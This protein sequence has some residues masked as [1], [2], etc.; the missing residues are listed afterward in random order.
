[1]ENHDEYKPYRSE[2]G[3]EHEYSHK[4]GRSSK[5]EYKQMLMDAY[6]C[7][8]DEGYTKALEEKEHLFGERRMKR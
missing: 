1:M 8:F 2:Y 5:H 3:R 6:E 7:G 4:D